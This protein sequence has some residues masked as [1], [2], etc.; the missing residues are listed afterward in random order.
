MRSEARCFDAPCRRHRRDDQPERV[1]EVG[2]VV[3]VR[4]AL[5]NADHVRDDEEEYDEEQ[6]HRRDRK[7][8]ERYLNFF[9]CLFFWGGAECFG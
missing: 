8:R 2:S 5:G 4:G 1:P 3:G 9:V 7:V 6:R